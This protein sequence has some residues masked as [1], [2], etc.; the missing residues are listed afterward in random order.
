MK[1]DAKRG[2]G[3]LPWLFAAI[4]MIMLQPSMLFADE[5]TTMT[6]SLSKGESYV[7]D[8][9]SPGAT[10]DIK[11]LSNP[12]ALVVH[13]EEPGKVALLGA[14]AG[15]WIVSVK[16]ATGGTVNYDVTISAV[17]NINDINHPGT[18]P[19]AI[20]GSGTG[21]GSAAPVVAKLD[22]GAGPVTSSSTTTSASGEATTVAEGTET[23]TTSSAIQIDP[24]SRARSASS[25]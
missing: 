22:P 12:H 11:V 8:N 10:P 20:V 3:L 24:A 16:M 15:E 21:V 6:L 7:I 25:S 1:M 19:A 18:A 4:S 9:V 14:D 5:G 17:G 23:V 2:C 13:D